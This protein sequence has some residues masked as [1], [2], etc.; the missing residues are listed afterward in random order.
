MT[1]TPRAVGTPLQGQAKAAHTNM[2]YPAHMPRG[3]AVASALNKPTLR[4]SQHATATVVSIPSAVVTAPG[5]TSGL[6]NSLQ[7]RGIMPIRTSTPSAVTVA[8]RAQ[9]PIVTRNPGMPHNFTDVQ[10]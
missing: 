4:V 9:S 6:Q 5:L 1:H 8:A 2:G 3:L 10:R 7:S